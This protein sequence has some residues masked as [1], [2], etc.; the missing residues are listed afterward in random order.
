MESSKVPDEYLRKLGLKLGPGADER[1]MCQ[2]ATPLSS[3]HILHWSTGSP[4]LVNKHVALAFPLEEANRS[5]VNVDAKRGSTFWHLTANKV[6]PLPSCE[7]L[8]T[9]KNDG[10]GSEFWCQ[11]WC[12]K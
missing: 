11:I 8:K 9:K 2:A 3:W 6:P 7:C 12:R 5:L 4:L 1:N 10:F